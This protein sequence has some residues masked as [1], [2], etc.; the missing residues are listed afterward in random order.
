MDIDKI[1]QI[2]QEISFAFEDH[3]S[4]ADK[5]QTF[6][7]LFHKYLSQ[8]DP[9]STMVPYD[10]IIKLGRSNLAEFDLMVKEMKEK[11]LIP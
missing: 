6:D 2:A 3:Y 7:A 11:S 9:D 10:A 1:G 8:V 5:R 4:D